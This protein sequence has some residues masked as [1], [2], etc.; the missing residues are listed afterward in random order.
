M[1]FTVQLREKTGK[2]SNKK[3]RKEGF[4]PGIIY[5]IKDPQPVTMRTE[6]ALRFIQSMHGATKVFNLTVET[7]GM[8]EEKKV[9]L[10]DY[11][12]ANWGK[13]LVHADFLEVTDHTEV[14]LEIP[15][16]V[17]NEEICPAIKEGGVLQIIRRS[18]PVK[19]AVKDIP[20]HI[21]IDVKE[22]LFGESIHVLD[23]DY[24]EGVEPVVYGRNFTVI[25]VAGRTEEEA[26]VEE[27]LE[28]VEAEAAEEKPETEEE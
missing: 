2:E 25:T 24:K 8:S 10:Q 28:A 14:N 18:V 26:E 27:E 12:L 23:L 19:C 9:I 15:I 17:V 11:Q 5:G 3:L 13:K 4:T 22:L 6:K 16:V 21:E 1:N 20:E 7:G